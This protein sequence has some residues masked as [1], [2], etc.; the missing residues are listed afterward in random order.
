M[1]QRLRHV[2]KM[3]TGASFKSQSLGSSRH[4]HPKTTIN[5]NKQLR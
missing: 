5:T 4:L 3:L 2:T 1:H